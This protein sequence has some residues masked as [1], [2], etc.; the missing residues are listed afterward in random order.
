MVEDGC[1]PCP[2]GLELE[3]S[4][5]CGTQVVN[6]G[7]CCDAEPAKGE[8]PEPQPETTVEPF[9]TDLTAGEDLVA[10]VTTVEIPAEVTTVEIPAEVTAAEIP[11]ELTAAEITS[12]AEP[13]TSPSGSSGCST[14]TAGTGTW[15]ISLFLMLVAA[16]WLRRAC[17]ANGPE[18]PK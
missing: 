4:C 17:R 7:Y 10:E 1:E 16:L 9:P 14:G 15:P 11:A 18:V 13:V 6:D 12:S 8:C 5:I 3:S 2:D